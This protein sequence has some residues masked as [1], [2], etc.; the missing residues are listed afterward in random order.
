MGG[1]QTK[2]IRRQ[3]GVLQRKEKGGANSLSHISQPRHP[4]DTTPYP[5][6]LSHQ[7]LALTYAQN[8]QQTPASPDGLRPLVA[9][10]PAQVVVP[11]PNRALRR[12]P[13]RCGLL[14][15]PPA[16]GLPATISLRCPSDVL[17]LPALLT[18]R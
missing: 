6:I 5:E 8:I 17:P 16:L 11:V 15:P 2:T 10:V 3:T 1:L 9:I 12:P 18:G 4:P 13:A 14:A 7:S